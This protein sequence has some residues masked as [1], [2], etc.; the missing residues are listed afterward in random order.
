MKFEKLLLTD[1]IF[2]RGWRRRVKMTTRRHFFHISLAGFRF[3]LEELKVK[4]TPRSLD[5]LIWC[6]F[7]LVILSYFFV[8]GTR[9]IS[10]FHKK[11]AQFLLLL[12]YSISIVRIILFKKLLRQMFT[13][14]ATTVK[15]LILRWSVWPIHL[16][17]SNIKIGR[18][19]KGHF[20]RSLPSP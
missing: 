3:S 12:Q 13:I 7:W 4:V 18:L 6:K 11:C 2:K 1:W 10:L 19:N 17:M 15:M 5:N 14:A 16:K 8:G 20:F 9:L